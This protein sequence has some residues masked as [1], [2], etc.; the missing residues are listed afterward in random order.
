MSISRDQ[1]IGALI[2]LALGI[3]ITLGITTL[4]QRVQ[5]APIIISPPDPTPLPTSTAVPSALR[6]FVNGAVQ[7][8][9]VYE[10]APDGLVQEAI[11][12]AGRFADEA[13]TAVVN[14]A[15]PLY[16]GLQVYVP[17][18][19]EEVAPVVIS[20]PASKTNI[21]PIPAN[22]NG[23]IN[24]NTA[25]LASLDELPGIGPS[26]AQKILDYREENGLFTAVE[27]IMNVSGIGDAKFEQVKELITVEE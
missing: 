1:V 26:T 14:L 7:R 17:I 5:P 23:L 20:N 3:A 12:A 9:G 13:N 6:I 15:Q 25:D 22:S 16:D 4:T 18:I 11:E 27:E 10:I 21:V 24:I 8:E 2:G 19:G